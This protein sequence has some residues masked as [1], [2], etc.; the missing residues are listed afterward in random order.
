MGRRRDTAVRDVHDALRDQRD[1]IDTT[2]AGRM[3]NVSLR[4]ELDTC[5][6]WFATYANPS[7]PMP[8]FCS[9]SCSSK[10]RHRSRSLTTNSYNSLVMRFW[11]KVDKEGP[12]VRAELTPC[13]IWTR[14]LDPNGYGRIRVGS[15]AHGTARTVLAHRLSFYFAHGRWPIAHALHVCDNPPCC[16]PDHLFEGSQADNMADMIGK[17]RHAFGA[18]NGQSKLT[19]DAVRE[20]RSSTETQDAMAKRYGIT[21]GH[22][23]YIRNMKV[24]THVT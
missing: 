12:I 2:P 20:I 7:R 3:P 16:R 5:S 8:R 14:H 15:K 10:F 6:R 4:C 19:E 9:R 18:L 23:S 17:R 13:W 11:A 21:S 24:W 22:V 1:Y